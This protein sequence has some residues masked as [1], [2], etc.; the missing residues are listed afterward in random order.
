LAGHP[1]E[2]LTGILWLLFG[3][4]GASLLLDFEHCLPEILCAE[5]AVVN[6]RLGISVQKLHV[7]EDHG[8]CDETCGHCHSAEDYSGESCTA[9]AF[10][11]LLLSHLVDAFSGN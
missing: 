8:E 7:M 10:V 1:K 2:G 3:D 5:F 9:K 6:L 11:V 4:F